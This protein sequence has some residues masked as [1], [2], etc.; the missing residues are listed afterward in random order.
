MSIYLTSG[1]IF[2]FNRSSVCPCKMNGKFGV[3]ATSNNPYLQV[4]NS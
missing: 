3:L 4:S 1:N 2:I